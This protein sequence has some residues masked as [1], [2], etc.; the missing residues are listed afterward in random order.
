MKDII[1]TLLRTF[2]QGIIDQNFKG[3][4]FAERIPLFVTILV[5]IAIVGYLIGGV[6]FAIIISKA[7]GKDVRNYGSGN[8]GATNISRVFGMKTAILTYFCDAFKTAV[9]VL[10]GIALVGS[11]GGFIAGFFTILGHAYPAYFR[12]RGGKGMACLATLALFTSPVCFLVLLA[13][14]LVLLFGF[15]MVSFAS[16]MTAIIYPFMLS[17]INGYGLQIIAALACSILVV[18]LHREN[19]ARIFAHEEP[20]IKIGKNK[21][22]GKKADENSQE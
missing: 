7:K 2:E 16:V 9:A 1:N 4:F 17:M 8:A 5:G 15:K 10:I 14:Y 13:I 19:L 20:K 22:G 21:Q 12:F 6:N 3:Q 18:F 11:L